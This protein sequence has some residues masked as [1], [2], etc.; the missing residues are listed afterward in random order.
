MGTYNQV[1]QAL[2]DGVPADQLRAPVLN[3]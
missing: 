3:L 2:S 1:M